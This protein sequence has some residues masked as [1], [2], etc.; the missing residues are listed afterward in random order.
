MDGVGWVDGW[1]D[2][3]KSDSA[4]SL[5]S[6]FYSKGILRILLIPKGKIGEGDQSFVFSSSRT[7]VLKGKY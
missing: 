3:W 7:L 4:I 6:A 5:F 1:M 2:G